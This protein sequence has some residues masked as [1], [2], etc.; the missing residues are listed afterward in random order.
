MKKKDK[1]TNNME[2]L[3]LTPLIE[4]SREELEMKDFPLE[5]ISE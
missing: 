4:D 2:A 1:I 5:E 3:E